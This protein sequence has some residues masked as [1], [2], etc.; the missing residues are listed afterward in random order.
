MED[1][2]MANDDANQP[3]D[4]T[5]GMA[6]DVKKDPEQPTTE[7]GPDL[8][9]ML[10]AQVEAQ[11]RDHGQRG[12]VEPA[13]ENVEEWKQLEAQK[14]AVELSKGE[15]A[16]DTTPGVSGVGT[17]DTS[18]PFVEIAEGLRPEQEKKV[19]ELESTQDGQNG[20]TNS[21]AQE[22]RT[23]PETGA[24]PLPSALQERDISLPDTK[25]IGQPLQPD[26]PHV[27]SDTLTSTT[28][29]PPSDQTE[30]P[31]AEREWETDSSPYSSSSDSSDSSSDEDSDDEGDNGYA[32]LS[33]TEQARILMDEAG[34]D[35]EGKSKGTG[36]VVK[37]AN[38]KFE[39]VIPKPDIVVTPEMRIEELGS[40]DAVVESTV[41]IRAKTTGEY[42]VLESGS[43]LCLKDRSV[44]GVV[45]DTMGKVE[46][47]LYTVRF[48]NDEAITEAGIAGKGTA[49]YY[50]HEHSTFV[51]TQ[52]LKG[53]KGSDASNFHDEEVG[54]DEMEFSDDEKEAEHRRILKLRK[55][56][57]DVDSIGGRGGRGGNRG[58]MQGRGGRSGGRGRGRG[59]FHPGLPTH[60]ENAMAN[61]SEAMSLNYDEGE[62]AEYEPLRRPSTMESQEAPHQNGFQ[63][64]EQHQDYLSPRFQQS[65]NRRNDNQRGRGRDSRGRSN[66]GNRGNFQQNRNHHQNN[67]Q[68]SGYQQ[69]P[70]Q[71]YGFNQQHQ[72]QSWM[73]PVPP[74]PG[75]P[76]FFNPVMMPGS[77]GL[78]FGQQQNG[79]SNPFGQQQSYGHHQ[80]QVGG[81]GGQSYHPQ[82]QQNG[83]GQQQQ[84]Q[85]YGG[86]W[87][88]N[89]AAAQQVQRQLEELRR[90]A[91]QQQ[92]GGGPS[93]G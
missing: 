4:E 72:Q 76:G 26:Q 2:A 77:P 30:V 47:P 33:P 6:T 70:Q 81:Y 45:A 91:Q 85:S 82:Q 44:I 51:F 75:M 32:L 11:A 40:S 88:N 13:V 83:Y 73:P 49:I 23:E 15:R 9:N 20:A 63:Q 78:N 41:L 54:D 1:T 59:G 61:A 57:I 65:D 60:P 22:S 37:T 66:R 38:E 56:G 86:A 5:A 64:P 93:Y 34:S 80:Q 31:P 68:Q 14:L 48:T 89:P 71:A 53:L 67:Y 21:H 28:L 24:I 87:A 74:P 69:Q 55:R 18:A 29:K 27:N 7:A 19:A 43:L 50:V 62:V 10:M 46:Q 17:A 39:E 90:Q 52:P 92:H 58:N 84:D 8:L 42:Q 35:D 79:Y 25:D 12:E 36:G 3:T 16:E